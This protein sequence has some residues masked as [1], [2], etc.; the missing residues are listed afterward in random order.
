MKFFLTFLHWCVLNFQKKLRQVAKRVVKIY[1]L[2]LHPTSLKF[3]SISFTSS[4]CFQLCGYPVNFLLQQVS[5]DFP[6]PHSWNLQNLDSLWAVLFQDLKNSS[7]QFFCTM[8]TK[9]HLV[10]KAFTNCFISHAMEEQWF[11]L[12]QLKAHRQHWFPQQPCFSLR[13][14]FYPVFF[15]SAIPEVQV[16]IIFCVAT[17]LSKGKIDHF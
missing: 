12:V 2:I 5:T 6:Q 3:L 4:T 10:S 15:V 8:Y 16:A 13:L 1:L 9:H 14:L 17:L 11:D 7:F